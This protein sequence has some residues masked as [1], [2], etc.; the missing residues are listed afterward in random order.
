MGG[1]LRNVSRLERSQLLRRGT[2]ALRQGLVRPTTI[3]NFGV[4]VLIVLNRKKC[5]GTKI[6]SDPGSPPSRGYRTVTK[7]GRAGESPP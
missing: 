5:S 2:G 6:R 4:R 1:W 7:S 3:G